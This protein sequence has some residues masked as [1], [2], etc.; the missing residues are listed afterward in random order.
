MHYFL[1]LFFFF[2]CIMKHNCVLLGK[3]TTP[4]CKFAPPWL[5]FGVIFFFEFSN[6]PWFFQSIF[7]LKNVQDTLLLSSCGFFL[8]EKCQW[9]S[10]ICI[11]LYDDCMMKSFLGGEN[12]PT[13]VENLHFFSVFFGFLDFLNG[14]LWGCLIIYPPLHKK[15]SA[16]RLFNCI[17]LLIETSSPKKPFCY[18][19]FLVVL[20]LFY[21][22]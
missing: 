11:V 6:P 1:G 16:Q 20:M 14:M 15:W 7:F 18:H 3:S 4:L 9:L 12:F 10:K 13:P 5:L 19:H 2:S 22:S 21:F 17:F 8:V